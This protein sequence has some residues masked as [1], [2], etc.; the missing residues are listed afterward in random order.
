[1]FFC[2]YCRNFPTHLS[3]LT[4]V[5]FPPILLPTSS[6]HFL[7]D[8]I[9]ATSYIHWCTFLKFYQIPFLKKILY[10]HMHTH[11]Y[12]RSAYHELLERR[13]FNLLIFVSPV[14]PLRV[15][16]YTVLFAETLLESIISNESKI[17][18]SMTFWIIP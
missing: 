1:M 9:A 3:I 4:Q 11:T 16:T 12:F 14:H 5:S 15:G 7:S 17:S 13:N 6:L 2:L 10:T 18:H 8:E